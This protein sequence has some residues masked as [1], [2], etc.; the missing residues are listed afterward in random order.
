MDMPLM[1]L[2]QA[3]RLFDRPAVVS[4]PKSANGS[5]DVAQDSSANEAQKARIKALYDTALKVGVTSGMAWQ[6][7]NIN[8]VVGSMSRDLD[9][10]Y[11]FGA[12]MIGQG[13]VPAIIT[14]ARNVY[15]QDGDYAVRT[16]AGVYKIEKQARFSS[17]A[18]NWREYLSFSKGR[19]AEVDDIL[20]A[21]SDADKQL[22]REVVK[23]GWDQGVEQA[24]IMLSQGMDRLNRDYSGMIRFHRFVVEG[25][26]T[27]P[28]IASED[29][30][31]THS[32]QTMA[33][34]ETLLRL[35]TL[36]EFNSKIGSWNAIIVSDKK[37]GAILRSSESIKDSSVV[38]KTESNVSSSSEEL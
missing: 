5:K 11:D 2:E 29:V 16:S 37:A 14:E 20:S 31:L 34:D 28:V 33:V 23:K 7:E 19:A 36:P 9:L 24:N 12:L 3:Q 25:K 13:V 17:V 30:A 38:T 32:G 18:P 6:I 21:K 27:L 22:W 8:K 35:T 4:Y 10:V 1:S 15:S 26:V